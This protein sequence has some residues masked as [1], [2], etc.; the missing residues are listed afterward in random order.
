MGAHNQRSCIRVQLTAK[1]N[2]TIWIEDVIELIE[3]EA[4]APTYP[5]LKRPDE[6]FVTELAYKNPKFSE[7]IARDLHLALAKVKDIAQFSIKVRNEESIHPYDV[8]SYSKSKNCN[9]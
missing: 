3:R 7:D 4:S 9:F 5:L 8:V 6:R 1:D 2:K